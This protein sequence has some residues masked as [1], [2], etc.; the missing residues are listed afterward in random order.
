[1]IESVENL[2][3]ER[4]QRDAG[5]GLPVMEVGPGEGAEFHAGGAALAQLR[6]PLPEVGERGRAGGHI[7]EQAARAITARVSRALQVFTLADALVIAL[8]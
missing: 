3:L 7:G 4:L 2:Q 6:V 1:M 5:E 8:V